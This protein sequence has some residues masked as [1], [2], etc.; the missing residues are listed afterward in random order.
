MRADITTHPRLGPGHGQITLGAGA[1]A[2][3]AIAIERNQGSA[4]WLG[5]NGWQAHEHAFPA[6][7]D[8]EVG[9]EA[10]QT[11]LT[12]GPAIVEP[13]LEAQATAA[14]FR[15]HVHGETKSAATLSVRGLLG[16]RARAAAPPPPPPPP[17][18]IEEPIVEPVVEPIR[19]ELKVELTAPPQPPREEPKRPN[20]GLIAAGVVVV[21]A[22]AGGAAWFVLNR[23]DAPTQTAAA[24]TPAPAPAPQDIRTEVR[25]YLERSPSAADAR[26]KGDELAKG[27][28]LDGAL[29]VY[30]YA[31]EKGDGDAA[32]ALARMYDPA[33]FT[34][35]TS[36]LPSPNADTA[37][38]WYETAA[39]AGSV[40]AQ[41]RLGT[42][43]KDSNPPK[44][45]EWLKKA[46]AAGDAE[47]ATLAAALE[48]K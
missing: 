38:R 48:K 6:G 20:L 5:P 41:R 37:Q 7:P 42:L 27:G 33:T 44:A 26:A 25:A 23:T 40:P 21:L 36:P 29:L 43:L 28:K 45:L 3:A 8:L 30:R 9:V 1:A 18:P 32:L 19:E 12:V 13:L 47:A 24:P 2:P 46:A 34:P 31:A 14:A 11:V 39:G 10:G 4:R 35:Q 17:P 22:V 15:L 16:S